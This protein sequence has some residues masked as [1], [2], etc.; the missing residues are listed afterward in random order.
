MQKSVSQTYYS[1]AIGFNALSKHLQFL[2]KDGIIFSQSICH[3]Y[4]DVLLE[5]KFKILYV[6][7]LLS[8]T[9]LILKSSQV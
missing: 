4:E 3:R 9:V 7:T 6:K 8:T 2:E 1:I 5:D